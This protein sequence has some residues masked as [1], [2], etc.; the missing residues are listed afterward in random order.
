MAETYRMGASPFIASLAAGPVFAGSLGFATLILSAPAPIPVNITW[1][2]IP[3]M[4]VVTASI[5]FFGFIVGILPCLIGSI[6]MGNLGSQL[7]PFRQPIA[8]IIA[9]AAIP[10]ALFL[11]PLLSSNDATST[12]SAWFY[13]LVMTGA[14][15][16][17]LCRKGAKWTAQAP[18]P[19]R[20]LVAHV[21]GG[22][23]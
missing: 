2:D 18:H 7:S 14:V 13:G 9:G 11:A 12:D 17:A 10:A 1:G 5:A 19:P 16:A 8:W 15:C 6:V 21:T 22:E 23:E 20:R 4:I 3:P